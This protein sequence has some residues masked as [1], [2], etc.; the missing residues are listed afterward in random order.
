[1]DRYKWYKGPPS[2]GSFHHRPRASDTDVGCQVR[3]HARRG[4]GTCPM[5]AWQGFL[6]GISPSNNIE[7]GISPSE[8]SDERGFN[9]FQP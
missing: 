6:D 3:G 9:W 7:N 2:Q 1:M 8:I 4:E 5:S